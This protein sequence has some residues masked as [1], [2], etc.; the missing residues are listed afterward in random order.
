M[1]LIPNTAATPLQS[2]AS[3]DEP[4]FSR[5]FILAG[6]GA[7]SMLSAVSF[8]GTAWGLPDPGPVLASRTFR[9]PRHTTHY[10]ESGPAN[11]PLMMFLH[12]W[13]ELSLIW[14]A[15]MAAFAAEGW[16]CVAPDMRG[17]GGSSAPAANHA[18]TLEAIVADMAELHDHLGGK[19]AI[20]VGHDWGSVVAGE[21]VAHQPD[22][23]R[24]LVLISVP[25]FPTTNAL[26]TLVPLVDRT[27]YP[28]DTYPDGQ[29][30][31][32]RY[33]TKHFDSA[34]ADLDADKTASLASIYRRGDPA[35]IGKPT[36]NAMVTQKGGRFGTAHRA[37][38]TKPDPALWPTAD[39]EMLVKTYE[40]HGFRAPCAWYMNDAANVAYARRS[41]NAGRIS[42]PVLFV[43][44]N[45]DAINTIHGNRSGDP[46]RAACADLSVT[47]LKGAHWLPVESKVELAQAIRTWLQ[48]KKL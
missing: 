35:S 37:P 5:R 36:P 38:P 43:N 47:S 34:V 18:Y 40:A 29:W 41:P 28:T 16:H 25:Y 21:L 12:G 7:A 6:M 2:P 33:Y 32:Y 24:G 45:W 30:D 17:Y 31:Y 8:S 15:Q 44:G 46:M 13:P 19:P 42:K 26:P 9:T 48:D 14:R 3:A 10:L 23:S 39:F 4:P 22:R 11:G 20:W 27:I 1:T